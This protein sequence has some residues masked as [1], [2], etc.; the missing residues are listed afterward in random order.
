MSGSVGTRVRASDVEFS[1][2]ATEHSL[3]DPYTEA[4]DASEE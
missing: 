4:P 3:N 2:E 1:H